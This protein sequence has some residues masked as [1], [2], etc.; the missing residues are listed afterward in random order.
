MRPKSTYQ[1]IPLIRPL[2][3]CTLLRPGQGHNCFLGVRWHKRKKALHC[4]V[5]S[6]ILAASSRKPATI[7]DSEDD[8]CYQ[9]SVREF[10]CVTG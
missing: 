7:A 2:G 9:L 8:Q 5:A 6:K 10:K 3:V 1:F 4:T